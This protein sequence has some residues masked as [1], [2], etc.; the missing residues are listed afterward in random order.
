MDVLAGSLNFQQVLKIL[1]VD[2]Q[3]GDSN[4]E[5]CEVIFIE[6][7]EDICNG[8]GDDALLL[9]TKGT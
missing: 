7:L 5:V 3:I 4:R 2:L 1:F 6:Q 9:I 8:P